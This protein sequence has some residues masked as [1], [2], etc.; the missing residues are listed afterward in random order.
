MCRRW[1]IR[2]TTTVTI[3]YYQ[4]KLN[5]VQTP[6][7][8][9]LGTGCDEE[10]GGKWRHVHGPKEARTCNKELSPA[11][12]ETEISNLKIFTIY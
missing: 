4:T 5:V 12:W 6:Q 3:E 8:Y 7:K 11:V 1:W 9:G 2:L 10:K